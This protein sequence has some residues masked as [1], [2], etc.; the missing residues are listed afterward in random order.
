MK[1][2]LLENIEK[3]GTKLDLRRV[4]PGYARN[5]LIPQKLAIPATKANL[6]WRDREINIIEKEKEK[7]IEKKK[8]LKEK[9]KDFVLK[10]KVRTGIK[11]ELFEKINREKIVKTLRLEGFNL[12]KDNIQL[13]EPIDKIGEY[14][15]KI[16]FGG[17]LETKIKLIVIKENQKKTK[18]KNKSL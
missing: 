1:V 3:L 2:I 10:I 18:L 13:K 16:I 9:L 4:K 12:E 8:K 7:V 14:P 5:F 6:I 11:G 15:I 17:G